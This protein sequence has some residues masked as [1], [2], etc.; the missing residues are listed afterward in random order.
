MKPEANQG[1]YGQVFSWN[2]ANQKKKKKGIPRIN[3]LCDFVNV[4]A[5]CQSSCQYCSTSISQ[6]EHGLISSPGVE[7]FEMHEFLVVKQSFPLRLI[8]SS[9]LYE[10]RTW[11]ICIYLLS[12]IQITRK[13][14]I[15]LSPAL[16]TS[17]CNRNQK[18]KLQENRVPLN[19]KT[20]L[21][22]FKIMIS[23][24]SYINA[25]SGLL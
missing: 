15:L 6:Q 5:S 13:A 23:C 2:H 3:V 14:R 7:Q 4:P 21:E 24:L 8:L 12:Y 20:G 19:F 22:D 17:S 1:C 9:S 11:W 25:T 10:L 16:F 18:D